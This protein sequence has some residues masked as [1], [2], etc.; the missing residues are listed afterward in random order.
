MRLRVTDAAT[1]LDLSEF[2]RVRVGAIV[3]A[4]APG[5]LEV[6][7]LGSFSE[8]AH[9]HELEIAVQQ[10]R[11]LRRLPDGTVTLA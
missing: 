4:S 3:E 2:L 8:E 10:W 1:A 9:R 7:L 6:S 11:L 5:H